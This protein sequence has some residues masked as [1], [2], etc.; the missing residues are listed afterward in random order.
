[1]PRF[2]LNIGDVG[3]SKL[4][5]SR[6]ELVKHWL[7]RHRVGCRDLHPWCL[8]AI[9]HP[10]DALIQEYGGQ[11]DCYTAV[12]MNGEKSYAHQMNQS[13]TSDQRRTGDRYICPPDFSLSTLFLTRSEGLPGIRHPGGWDKPGGYL[14]SDRQ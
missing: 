4:Q 3:G 14:S 13:A 6:L 7:L 11:L 2:P 8:L 1:M 10:P 5:E 12:A 9:V